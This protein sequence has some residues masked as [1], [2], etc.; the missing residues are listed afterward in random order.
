MKSKKKGSVAGVICTIFGVIILIAVI[1][2][3][4]PMVVPKIMGNEVYTVVS[5]S[6]EPE[7]SV[8]SLVV[9]EP[10][11]GQ[12]ME[13]GDIVAYASGGSVVTHRIVEN[14]I[15]DGEMITKGDANP[16]EDAEPISYDNIIGE[17]TI[18]IPVIGAYMEI[19][20]SF[21]GKL[22]LFGAALCGLLLI[23]LG[24]RLRR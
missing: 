7:I 2:T 9:V 8:G 14:H 20:A 22:Y 13:E 18:H 21:I 10:K 17:V 19:F 24:S 11:E 4:V 1:A 3:C 5:G 6:M 15:I 23:I 12:D 16:A